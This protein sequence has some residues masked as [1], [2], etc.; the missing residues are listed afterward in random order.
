[1]S[2]VASFRRH[3][4]GAVGITEDVGI[5]VGTAPAENIDLEGAFGYIGVEGAELVL[6]K[7]QVDS[8]FADLLLNNGCEQSHGVVG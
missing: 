3:H 2:A 4:G 7:L 1:M 5:F 8:R 6:P